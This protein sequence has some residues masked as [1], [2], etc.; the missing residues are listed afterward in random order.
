MYMV[1]LGIMERILGGHLYACI[2]MALMRF[3]M[4]S[5]PCVF[6]RPADVV[7]TQSIKSAAGNS[8]LSRCFQRQ[9]RDVIEPLYLRNVLCIVMR[10]VFNGAVCSINTD[11]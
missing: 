2:F 10:G 9:P 4:R 6:G 11:V 5:K 8:R 1:F 7:R 3:V